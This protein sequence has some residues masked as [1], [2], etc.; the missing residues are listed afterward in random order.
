[1]E[2]KKN[3]RNVI[4]LCGGREGKC[5]EGKKKK[6]YKKWQE[7]MLMALYKYYF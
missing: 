4:H 6:L 7:L 5:D 1:M 2:G 3:E